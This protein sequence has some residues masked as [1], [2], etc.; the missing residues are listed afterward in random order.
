MD[1]TE[2]ARRIDA[3][4][5]S[6]PFTITGD[7][8]GPSIE[9]C[10]ATFFGREGLVLDGASRGSTTPN[11]IAVVGQSTAAPGGLAGLPSQPVV[12]TFTIDAAG[13]VDL[14]LVFDQL[15]A[16]WKPSTS[17]PVLG[18]TAFDELTWSH[19]T[20]TLSSSG[21]PPLP[22]A[23]PTEI[24]LPPYSPALRAAMQPGLSL[25]AT[26]TLPATTTG[27]F[28]ALLGGTSWSVS[29]PI[30]LPASHPSIVLS[31]G[32]QRGF[33]IGHF[34]FPFSLTLA[35]G[36][37]QA[38]ATDPIIVAPVLQLDADVQ[39]ERKGGGAPFD[40]PFRARAGGTSQSTLLI[41]TALPPGTGITVDEIGDLIGVAVGDSLPAG[42]AEFPGF[43]HIG[44]ER[45]AVSIVSG[46]TP[47]LLTVSATVGWVDPAPL[48]PIFGGLITFGGMAVTFT[49]FPQ[50][51]TRPDGTT[52]HLTAEIVAEATI[53]GGKLDA[54][55]RLPDVVFSCELEEGTTI[56]I[57]ALVEHAAGG[58]IAMAKVDCTA[59]RLFGDVGN[60]VYRFQATVTDDWEF[61]VGST[62]VALTSIGFDIDWMPTGFDGEVVAQFDIA[63]TS[64]FGRATY[65]STTK[66]WAF[67]LGTLD[68]AHVDITDLAADVATKFGVDLP[69]NTP[70]LVLTALNLSYDT[71]TRDFTFRCDTTIE[72]AGANVDL[73]VE[74]GKGLYK[75]YL[76]VGDS[77]F[78]LDFLTT[79]QRSTLTAEWVAT[80]EQA[81]LEFGDIAEALHLPKPDLPPGLDL[82]LRR[83]SLLYE[84]E[85][86]KQILRIEADSATYGKAVLL[87]QKVGTATQ[88]FAGLDVGHPIDLSDL[89]LLHSLLSGRDRAAIDHL[90]VVLSSADIDPK[91]V[92]ALNQMIDPGY[93]TLPAI[94]TAS[95]VGLS[96][97][98]ELGPT[99]SAISLG[100]GPAPSDQSGAGNTAFGPPTNPPNT[101]TPPPP[102]PTT[103]PAQSDGT[104]WFNVQRAFGPVT[105]ERIG[106][107][108]RDRALW[109]ALDA[110]IQADGLTINLLGAAIG[111]PITGFEPEFSLDGLGID[112]QRPPLEIGGS[113]AKVA[114]TGGAT[115][116]YAGSVVV[117]LP[118][119]GI[120][121]YGSYADVGGHPSMFVFLQVQ[122]TFG[123]PPAFFVDGL[124]GGFGY[125]SSLRIPGQNEV[126]WCPLV[127]GLADPSAVG[128]PDATPAQA[129]AALTG[130][131]DPWVSHSL[132]EHWIAAGL[133]FSTYE[134]LQSN[135]L[136]VVELGHQ[137]TI[138]LLGISTARFPPDASEPAYAQVQLQLEAVLQPQQGFFGISANLTRNSFVLDPAC[139]LTGGFAFYL[140][141]GPNEHAGDFV[142]T[143]GGYHP[144]FDPP[145][146]YPAEPRVG[147]TW[148]VD[149]TVQV[150]GSAYFA[151]T[152]AAIMAGGSLSVT[153]HDGNLKAWFTAW[154]DLI[155]WWRP[156]H[157]VVDIGVSIGASYRL[158]LGFT[159]LTLKIELGADITLWGPKT[160]G[161]AHVHWWIISFSVRFGS[162]PTSQPGP[163]AQ[164]S[165]FTPLLPAAKDVVTVQATSG[166]MAPP[167][168]AQAAPLAPLDEPWLVRRSGF[169]LTTRSAIPATHL[170]VGSKAP[171]PH[172]VGDPIDIRPMQRTGLS[173]A[174]RL[175]IWRDGTEID[176]R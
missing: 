66:G 116:E 110:A 43:E 124:V 11:S 138:A 151:L 129:L 60:T 21:G 149:A 142:V 101:P 73:G 119:W 44:L 86:G 23:Y 160:G 150:R 172:L 3:A 19:P 24:G 31:T 20:L 17:L 83:A 169:S 6:P 125:N 89:P 69:T 85:A 78:E 1:I 156:F 37:I 18:S 87:A 97:V 75:G 33:A 170:F 135:A 29:G 113:F 139:V 115:F 105:I 163:L 154:A 5:A 100:M 131:A 2:L 155:V 50:G 111:S 159:S 145:S 171:Q 112:Y 82:G 79:D 55:I 12:A 8:F 62:H 165:D 40:L 99:R 71:A 9:R 80:D 93:P 94:G 49:W 45:V 136:L 118:E 143:L 128:G 176:V 95:M 77:Y 144:A 90:Q 175:S 107:R 48:Y 53:A 14:A 30:V 96:A 120:T 74:I 25:Q 114:P 103:P 164:W 26:V 57:A 132:G 42:A 147:F 16:G 58:T 13:I 76:W 38:A 70:H 126:I 92:P 84:S 22:P 10:V 137:L 161:I 134:L 39:H 64:L 91:L 54:S 28:A 67:E 88:W 133:S 63:G 59:L 41:E 36:L 152:P 158:D 35:T 15:P 102:P 65:D 68:P 4:L 148:T 32:P 104:L 166:L 106:A 174:Q 123:G 173:S 98:V 127:A 157:F 46:P 56:D 140:W 81:L 117:K 51:Y 162:S 153:F 27:G 146:Y 121:A 61:A 168:T 122:G 72:I 141:F 108:Y 130:G 47:E 167:P 52:S 109:I 34:T 7:G